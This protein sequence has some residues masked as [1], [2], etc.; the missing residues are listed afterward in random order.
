MAGR[1]PKLTPE[2]HKLLV[3][4]LQNGHFAET[5]CAKAKI[6]TTSF[7]AWLQRGERERKGPYRELLEATKSADADFEV[8]ALQEIKLAAKGQ[9]EQ[10]P[11]WQAYAWILERRH[12]KKWGRKR[13]EIVGDDG[14][15]ISA[16]L[17]GEIGIA[18]VNV[19]ISVNGQGATANPDF[20][21]VV[22]ETGAGE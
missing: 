18:G 14:Q 10:K 17:S 21:P 11:Q 8:I 19:K 13:L 7:Y 16:A 6:S 4:M 15:P 2:V 9:G 20:G 5:A 3:Q 12:P 22:D 1:K